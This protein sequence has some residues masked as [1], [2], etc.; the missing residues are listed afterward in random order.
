MGLGPD[1]HLST[2]VTEADDSDTYALGRRRT[3]RDDL[4]RIGTLLGNRPDRST[5]P[6]LS[7]LRGAGRQPL[8]MGNRRLN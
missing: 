5:A 7:D 6:V 3:G 4:A 1:L 8:S 2:M